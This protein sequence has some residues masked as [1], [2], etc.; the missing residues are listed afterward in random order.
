MATKGSAPGFSAK[1]PDYLLPEGRRWP[2]KGQQEVLQQ[3]NQITYS[4]RAG[5]GHQNVSSR[6][7]SKET[8]WLTSWWQVMVS[9]GSSAG[10][11]AKRPDHLLPED[12][13]W[14]PKG[15]QQVLQ[16]RD[17]ITYILRAGDGNQRVSGMFCS[18][19]TISLTTCG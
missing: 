9:K 15:Q 1:R 7:C 14:P 12:R 13:G 10:F 8:R 3:K 19:E 2:P 11:A 6:F 5:R 17:Q 4:L 16:Q 18:K